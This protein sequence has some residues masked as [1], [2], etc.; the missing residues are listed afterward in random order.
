MVEEPIVAEERKPLKARN[1]KVIDHLGTLYATFGDFPLWK[2]DNVSFGVLK[3]CDGERTVGQIS[4][5]LASIINRSPE[6]V[7]PTIEEILND[8][9]KMK[10]IE[11]I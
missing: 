11:W 2:I 6:D 4:E 8:L 7:R 3:L 10:F 9:Y 5:E 1:L